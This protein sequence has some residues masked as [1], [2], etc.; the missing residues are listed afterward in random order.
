MA[1]VRQFNDQI[2][3]GTDM[4]SVVLSKEEA[5]PSGPLDTLITRSAAFPGFQQ[6]ALFSAGIHP[7]L[8]GCSL[9]GHAEFSE[10]CAAAGLVI[11]VFA[12]RS[13]SNMSFV[14]QTMSAFGR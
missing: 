14:H 4:E 8:Q 10:R 12:K 11:P 13:G 6:A 2:K 9:S 3:Q 5:A 7:D 1:Q